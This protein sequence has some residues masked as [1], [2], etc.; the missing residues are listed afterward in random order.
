MAVLKGAVQYGYEPRIISTRVC[1]HTYGVLINKNF[2][3]GKDPESKKF[4]VDGECKCSDAFS[5]HVE[6][7]QAVHINESTKAQTYYPTYA[8]QTAIRI[9][10]YTSTEK[11]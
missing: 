2:E 4:M 8:D 10:I 3:Q 1:K 7:G 5:K 6:I 9:A 11:K